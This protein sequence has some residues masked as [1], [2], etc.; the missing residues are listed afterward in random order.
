[1]VRYVYDFAEGDQTQKDLLGGKGA[2]LAEMLKIGL[3]VPPGFTVTTEACRAYLDHRIRAR[4]AGPRAVTEKLAQPSRRSWDD[5]S[6]TA[7]RTRSCSS[8]RSGAKFS[9]P[10]MM[11]TVLNIGSERR[12]SPRPGRRLQGR[13]LRLGLLPPAH[14][15]VRQD[16]ARASRAS[17]SSTRSTRPRRRDNVKG[18]HRDGGRGPQG[19]RGPSYKQIVKEHAGYRLPAGSSRA[20][21]PSDPGRLQL[22]EH[23]AREAVP[24]TGAHPRP[25]LG[26]AVDVQAMVYGYVGDDLGHGRGVDPCTATCRNGQPRPLLDVRAGRGRRLRRPQQRSHWTTWANID[27]AAHSDLRSATWTCWSTTTRTSATSSSRSSTA[28]STCSRPVS[29]SAQQVL[30]SG[31]RSSWSTRASSTW[32]RRFAASP[33]RSWSS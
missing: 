24:P 9:M 2:N 29:A 22:L 1:M 14:L 20:A 16:R 17:T 11:E 31:S 21:R 13:A 12:R 28:S 27:A 4:R 15:D 18:R 5:S 26:T 32:T 3:N 33:A 19:A 6:A 8:V 10:G 23:R 7:T 30:R 25:Y